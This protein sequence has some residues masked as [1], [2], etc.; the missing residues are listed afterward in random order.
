[1]ALVG[2]GIR[3]KKPTVAERTRRVNEVY[4]LLASGASRTQILQHCAEK[5]DV[6]T[7][8]TDNYIAEARELI[9]RDCDMSRP[10]F[11]AEALAG[12][13]KVRQLAESKGNHQVVVNAIRLQ[14]ELVGLTGKA[15]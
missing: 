1:V 3:G 4:G 15:S 13:R 6:E 7:R 12:L 8:C 5:F 2:G 10:A 9:E 14:A 11:L